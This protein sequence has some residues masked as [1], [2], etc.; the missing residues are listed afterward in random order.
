MGNDLFEKLGGAIPRSSAGVSGL[1]SRKTA[2]ERKEE[3]KKQEILDRERAKE[4]TELIEKIGEVE[5]TEECRVKIERAREGF[6]KLERDAKD[7]VKQDAR[8]TLREAEAKYEALKESKEEKST[9]T[10]I[11]VAEI[12]KSIYTSIKKKAVVVGKTKL[13]GSDKNKGKMSGE[14]DDKKLASFSISLEKTLWEEID[15]AAT[16]NL[17]KPAAYVRKV[18]IEELPSYKYSERRKKEGVGNNTPRVVALPYDMHE[19]IKT[20]AFKHTKGNV[21][22][23]CADI[24]QK[25]LRKEN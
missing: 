10:D 16:H 20:L 19:K 17:I 9:K 7:L 18:I 13:S 8:K 2:E 15:R 14:K 5:L 22:K 6:K 25:G 21:S 12:E 23:I 11:P 3:L 24:L 4:V 1:R